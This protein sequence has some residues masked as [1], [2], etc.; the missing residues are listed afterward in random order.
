MIISIKSS[1]DSLGPPSWQSLS[2]SISIFVNWGKVSV[3][4]LCFEPGLAM[5]PAERSHNR[6]LSLPPH[7][8]SCRALFLLFF[9]F[10]NALSHLNL[11]FYF[12]PSWTVCRNA[13]VY[14]LQQCSFV[15]FFF[16][17]FLLFVVSFC[18]WFFDVDVL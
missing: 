12:I 6:L 16:C 8:T 3:S 1:G 13:L 11:T 2:I 18:Y 7:F 5:I 17:L 14:T 10:P 9:S 4:A 15:S